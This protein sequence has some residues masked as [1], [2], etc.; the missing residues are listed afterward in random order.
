MRRCREGTL[1]YSGFLALHSGFLAL[2]GG[3][4]APHRGLL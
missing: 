3:F 2:Y 1:S 4:P